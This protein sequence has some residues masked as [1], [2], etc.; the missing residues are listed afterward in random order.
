M[1]ENEYKAQ[2]ALGTLKKCWQCGHYFP[3]HTLIFVANFFHGNF[4]CPECVKRGNRERKERFRRKL[5]R[6]EVVSKVSTLG[7]GPKSISSNLIPCTKIK[8]SL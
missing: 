3:K 1:E 6:K 7:C 2:C 4:K 8:E 5:K